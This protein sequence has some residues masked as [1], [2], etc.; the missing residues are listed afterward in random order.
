MSSS[1][2][3][4]SLYICTGLEATQQYATT[5][6][7][8]HQYRHGGSGQAGRPTDRHL[9]LLLAGGDGAGTAQGNQPPLKPSNNHPSDTSTTAC[10]MRQPPTWSRVPTTAGS[11]PP[12]QAQQPPTWNRM[13]TKSS[14]VGCQ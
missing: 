1:R 4:S 2:S 9:A 5:A 13:P 10:T 12:Q 6:A 7:A 3:P 8:E 11:H 14:S